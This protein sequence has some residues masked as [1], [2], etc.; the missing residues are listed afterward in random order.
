MEDVAPWTLDPEAERMRLP[1]RVTMKL[2]FG[3]LASAPYFSK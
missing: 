1:E 3:L 2:P